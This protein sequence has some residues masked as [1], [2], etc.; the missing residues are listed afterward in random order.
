MG[1]RV[2]L[3]VAAAL[4][5][6]AGPAPA[7]NGQFR[8]FPQFVGTW[9]LDAAA[10]TGRMRMA[11]PPAV[12]LAIATTSTDI[13]VTSTLDLPPETRGGGRRL[14]T[15]TPPPVV[16]KLNGAP[17]L[18]YGGQYEYSYTFM[19]VADALVLTEKT[20]NWVRRGD[21]LMSNRD[22]FTMVTDA[23]HVDGNVLT[24]HRQ[25]TSV[26][27]EGEIHVMATPEMNLRQTYVYRRVQPPAG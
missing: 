19:L 6:A 22:A 26:N 13:T 12:T 24:L 1:L 15:N 18:R 20:S 27:G 8:T 9:A 16:Y 7:Q 21:P 3:V 17:S 23:L 10:S 11:P 2:S 25:L 4:L 14:A 5:G